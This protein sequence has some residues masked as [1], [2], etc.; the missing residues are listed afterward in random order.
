MTFRDGDKIYRGGTAVEIVRALE[1]DAADY[2]RRGESLRLFL[3]WS[4][5]RLGDCIPPREL[6][7]SDRLDDETLALNYLYLRDEYEI[8]RFSAAP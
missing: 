3:R 1:Q 4:L 6:D 5:A 2:P 7:L 8:G